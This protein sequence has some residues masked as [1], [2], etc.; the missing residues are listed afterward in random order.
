M[1]GS[2]AAAIHL[3][4]VANGIPR[5]LK[6]GIDPAAAR[7][8]IISNGP[9]PPPSPPALSHQQEQGPVKE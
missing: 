5:I 7:K 4:D 2:P 6:P 8:S 1:P 3:K 9:C